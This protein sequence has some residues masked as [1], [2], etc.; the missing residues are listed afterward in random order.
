LTI[1]TILCLIQVGRYGFFGSI[2]DVE[3]AYKCFSAY[4]E[5]LKAQ[6]GVTMEKQ[7]LGLSDGIEKTPRDALSIR[8]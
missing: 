2:T 5:P 4:G 8:A 7:S 1:V 3:C 6:V